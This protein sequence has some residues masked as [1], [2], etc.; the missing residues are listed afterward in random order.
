[1]AAKAAEF[2]AAR[3]RQNGPMEGEYIRAIPVLANASRRMGRAFFPAR[4]APQ[5][6]P[7]H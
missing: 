6:F 1:M 4:L 2:V 3:R 7:L 5:E